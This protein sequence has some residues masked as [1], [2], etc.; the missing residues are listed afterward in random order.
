MRRSAGGGLNGSFSG[1]AT[2]AALA[3]QGLAAKM[4]RASSNPSGRRSI[5]AA[6]EVS[7]GFKSR[8]PLSG[9]HRFRLSHAWRLF[10]SLRCSRLGSRRAVN[11]SR[12]H[13][14][15]ARGNGDF[16][17]VRIR[18]ANVK[19]RALYKPRAR[20]PSPRLTN[21]GFSPSDPVNKPV[22]PHVRSTG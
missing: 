3:H 14:R 18:L 15:S 20:D 2:A 7:E 10:R 13:P 12:E 9:M 1:T 19:H 6:R 8:H 21:A 17:S 16:V 4:Q 5:S 22:P 11:H